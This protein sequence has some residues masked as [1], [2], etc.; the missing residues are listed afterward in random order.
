MR[1]TCWCATNQSSST[2]KC[3][4]MWGGT[5]ALVGIPVSALLKL[6]FQGEPGTASL[7]GE[8][9]ERGQVDKCIQTHSELTQCQSPEPLQH[10]L[11]EGLKQRGLVPAG[12]WLPGPLAI[13]D[14]T[15]ISVVLSKLTLYLGMMLCL[16][17]ALQWFLAVPPSLAASSSRTWSSG[18]RTW[19]MNCV[20]SS[21]SQVKHLSG[22]SYLHFSPGLHLPSV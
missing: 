4:S 12:A 8:G 2:C 15:N 13:Q 22:C 3:A 1:S 6:C 16:S 17:G 18:S 9:R 21:T 20:A 10:L 11:Q 7:P 14:E 5:D 19:S